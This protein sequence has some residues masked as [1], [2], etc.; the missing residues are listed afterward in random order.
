MTT[1][2]NIAAVPTTSTVISADVAERIE[3]D[4][5]SL[6]HLASAIMGVTF[7][8]GA[9]KADKWEIAIQATFKAH[10]RFR[11]AQKEAGERAFR[12]GCAVIVNDARKERMSAKEEYDN[13]S[14]ALKAAMGTFKTDIRIPVADF[15][16]V[17][18]G[19]TVEQIVTK[20]GGKRGPG[21]PSA[22]DKGFGYKVVKAADGKGWDVLVAL[23]PTE[24]TKEQKDARVGV[25]R[26]SKEDVAA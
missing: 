3:N 19:L 5:N 9:S 1:N 15:A 4:F 7:P 12:E 14:P 16:D 6:V 11:K 13:L 17:F 21:R 26:R 2:T 8:E 18:P 23:D 24:E 22:E 10:S 20:L 25:V